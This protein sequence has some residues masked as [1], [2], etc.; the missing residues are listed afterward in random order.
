M[1]EQTDSRGRWVYRLNP[2]NPCEVQR[3]ANKPRAMWQSYLTYSDR[4]TAKAKL[5]RLGKTAAGAHTG[6]AQH[7]D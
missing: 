2:A 7:G 4:H 3:K 1:I 5:L 6:D